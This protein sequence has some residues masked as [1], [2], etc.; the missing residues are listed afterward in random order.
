MLPNIGLIG[1]YHAGTT[2][3]GPTLT[4]RKDMVLGTPVDLPMPYS[5][6][7]RGQL[8]A[9]R[10]GEYFFAV[11]ANGPVTLNLDGRDI[12][13]HLPPAELAGGP[14]Y[15]QVGLYLEAGWHAIDLR[16]TPANTSDLRVLWQPPGSG[17][18][19]LAGRYLLP[20]EAALTSADRP[21]PPAPELVDARLGDDSFALTMNLGPYPTA[22]SLPPASL[23]LLLAEPVWTVGNGCGLDDGQFA[24]P[25]G[26]A[27]DMDNGRIYVADAGN[28]R[29]VELMLDTGVVVTTFDLAEFQEPVDVAI[30]PQGTLLV[31]DAMTQ[32]IYRIDRAT[33][34]AAT[35]TLGTS[36][37]RPRGFGV[38]QAGN[39][40]VADTGGARVALLDSTGSLL[41]QYGGREMGLGQGQPVDVLALNDQWW[42]IAA[43]HGRLWRLDVLGSVTVSERSNTLTGPHLAALP[44]GSVQRTVLYLAPNGQPRG[45][46]GYADTFV[47]PTGVA[48]S[49]HED[50]L[51][52]LVVAD[53]ATCTVSLWRLRA[54]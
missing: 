36:F 52:N 1:T 8:A 9:P 42:T 35:L 5:V 26:I 53:S 6:Q 49:L 18:L 12:L 4:E 29:V 32:N 19:L 45:Q 46:L 7:W 22:P 48:A 17:P 11:T 23:P 27:L 44:D 21:L 40:G 41:V 31:L 13:L 39:I 51:F 43:D 24:S 20:T 2:W 15:S 25:R 33:G 54:E 16:Y 50:G 3:D 37:Y 28:R 30:D 10:A 38:D 14:G 34:E 47:N